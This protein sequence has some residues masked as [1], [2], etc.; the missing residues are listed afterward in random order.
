MQKNCRLHL[1]GAFIDRKNRTLGSSTNHGFLQAAIPPS[2][3]QELSAASSASFTSFFFTEL[4]N[5]TKRKMEK[6]IIR[7]STTD[8]INEPY[9]M[10]TSA[11][12]PLAGVQ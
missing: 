2:K 11:T 12:S 1:F 9:R 10:A 3:E 7:K 5:L 4:I 8:C 6:A